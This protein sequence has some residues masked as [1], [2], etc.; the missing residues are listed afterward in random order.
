[1]F[2][3]FQEKDNFPCAFSHDGGIDRVKFLLE[4]PRGSHDIVGG[5]AVGPRPGLRGVGEGEPGVVD[6]PVVPHQRHR[7]LGRLPDPAPSATEG[8]D[9]RHDAEHAFLAPIHRLRL[10]VAEPD[11]EVGGEALAGQLQH[12]HVAAAVEVEG[13]DDGNRGDWTSDGAH[14]LKEGV[15]DLVRRDDRPVRPVVEHFS[16][17]LLWTRRRLERMNMLVKK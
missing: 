10:H 7:H 14:A 2:D 13:V 8:G 6:D 16:V 4:A 3:F 11:L 5:E 1:M 17:W 9:V 12:R 15:F